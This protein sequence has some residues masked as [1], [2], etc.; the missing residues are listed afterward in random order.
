MESG[1]ETFGDWLRQKR[2]AAGLSLQQVADRAGVSKQRLSD[3]ENNKRRTVGGRLPR[4]SEDRVEAIGAAV[5][6]PVD[7]ARLAAGLAPKQVQP[8]DL[9]QTRLLNYFNELPE[10]QQSTALVMIEAM[11]RQEQSQ[12][13]QQKHTSTMAKRKKA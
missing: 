4:L 10:T 13:R 12:R 8:A 11:W 6:A 9:L 5:F 2:I 1:P 3:I 7:E